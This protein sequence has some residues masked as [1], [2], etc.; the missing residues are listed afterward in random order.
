MAIDRN[1]VSQQA[2]KLVSQGKIDAA[3]SQYELLVKDNS[4]D[5]NTINKIGDLYARLGKKREAILQFNKIGEHYTHDGFFLKAIAIY[6]KITKLD[7][8]HLDAYQ[9]LADL[10]AQQGLV[11]E[12]RSQYEMVGGQYLRAGDIRRAIGAY[13]S[14]VK[15]DPENLKYRGTLADLLLKDGKKAEAV[16][17]LIR[18]GAE[19]ER[20]GLDR[21][22]ETAYQKAAGIQPDSPTLVARLASARAAGGDLEGAIK[23]AKEACRKP[24]ASP[25]LR[26]VLGDLHVKAGQHAEARSAFGGALDAAPARSDVRLRLARTHLMLGDASAAFETVAPH[27]A[28]LLKEG[29]GTEVAELLEEVSTLDPAQAEPLRRLTEIYA[30]LKDP[31]SSLRSAGRLLDLFI[32]RRDLREGRRVAEALVR[33]HPGDASLREKLDW[34]AGLEAGASKPASTPA[35]PA[36]MARAGASTSGGRTGTAMREAESDY[37]LSDDAGASGD[38]MG[39]EPNRAPEAAAPPSA[40]IGPV[41]TLD[42]PAALQLESEDEDFIAEHMTEADVFVKYGLGDRAV[43]QLQTVIERY[44]GYAPAHQRLKEVYLEDGN[45]EGTRRAMVMLVKSHLAAGDSGLAQEALSELLRFEPDSVEAARLAEV[46]SPGRATPAQGLGFD[47]GFEP[48]AAMQDPYSTD[49]V[50]E[51]T[52]GAETDRG[53]SDERPPTAE[54]LEEVDFYTRH[55]LRDEAVAVLRRLA[56][57]Y[58]SHTEI[59]SRMKTA[60]ALQPGAG[61]PAS[62]KPGVSHAATEPGGYEEEF[63]IAA[64]EEGEEPKQ[65]QGASPAAAPASLSAASKGADMDLSDLA[66]EIDAAL[67]LQSDDA[68]PVVEGAE[69]TPEGHSLEEIVHAFKKGI[70][71]QVS[72]EDVDTHYNLGIA[73]KEMG[74]LDEAIGEFQFASKDERFLVDCCSM[75][76]VCFREKGMTGLAV[77][78]YRRGIDAS[79]S[80]DEGTMLGLR[81]DL[82]E[83]LA[84]MGQQREALDLYTEIFGINSKYRDVAARIRDLERTLPA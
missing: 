47:S 54:E 20:K 61:G 68:V 8:T 25:D 18:I 44:P 30:A 24:G 48:D 34:L 59:V 70:E 11:L 41:G 78:W 3:I 6:K 64:M 28:A 23:M 56:A 79:A 13:L 67:S 12:A 66:A 10:Y 38:R 42:L 29:K 73:Y 40:E 75:L 74:L 83:L 33:Q 4:R 1:K 19:L 17:E 22:A 62:A 52:A 63:E 84:E 60:M 51:S 5:L 7:P 71:Q 50:P 35:L 58:G 76:G 2:E 36:E 32:S 39:F 77:K 82:A 43:E 72:A 55:G 31:E 81:Y 65:T 69:P 46:V 27:S 45:R 80:R 37:G 53:E 21:E 14:L 9:S 57:A 26:M 16:E 49:E 15:V